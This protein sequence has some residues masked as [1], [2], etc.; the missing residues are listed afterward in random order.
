[1]N[2]PYIF[3]IETTMQQTALGA[4]PCA[5]FDASFSS[6]L[7]TEPNMFRYISRSKAILDVTLNFNP[8]FS[9]E[10]ALIR[11]RGNFQATVPGIGST[12]FR[13]Y[14]TPPGSEGNG[15]RIPTSSDYLRVYDRSTGFEKLGM[16]G[17]PI[18]ARSPVRAANIVVIAH[19]DRTTHG[20][21]PGIPGVDHYGVIFFPLPKSF[22]R[23]SV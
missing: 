13:H 18:V 16:D 7:G 5:P 12:M 14:R 20:I 11:G 10:G 22:G 9:G 17:K 21:N 8:T 6:G 19:V 3:L 2:L 4:S 23:R 15:A 1:M